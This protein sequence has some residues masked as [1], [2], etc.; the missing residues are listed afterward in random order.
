MSE[1]YDCTDPDGRAEGIPAAASAVRRG[2]IVVLPTDT[3][4]GIGCDAFDATAVASVLAAKG[5]GRDMPPPV[6]IPTARTAQGLATQVPDYA[7]R[8]MER[9]WPGPLTLVLKAQTSLHWDLGETNGTV[10]L[11]VPDHEI[12]L[13]L[14]GDIGP[15]AVTSANTTGD[16]AARTVDEAVG[17]LGES[18]GVYLDG[19]PVSEGRPSTIVDC[20]GETPVTLRLG[21]I[22]QDEL[23][24]ALVPEPV[25]EAPEPDAGP[26]PTR[27][28]TRRP[29]RGA[30]PDAE[31]ETLG[32]WRDVSTTEGPYGGSS[33]TQ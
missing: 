29:T 32:E 14:L 1:R 7:Q 4:Y 28:S 12:T 20:T 16:P 33:T 6:L 5:R 19:G 9:F 17:M 13:E 3:V 8:L 26:S 2:E 21:A 31:P 10:A 22:T 11:R 23:D 30:E 15:M 24:E 27:S 25:L 18:V